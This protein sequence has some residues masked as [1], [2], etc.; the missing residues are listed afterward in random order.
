MIL[1][2]KFQNMNFKNFAISTLVG[3]IVYYIACGVFYGVVFPN[4]HPPTEN[5]SQLLVALGCLF[6]AILIGYVFNQ[7]AHFTDW[8]SGLKAGAILGVISGIGMACFAFCNRAMDTT[9]FLEEILITVIT[10]AIL[11]ATVAFVNGKLTK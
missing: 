5:N 9:L 7:W 1:N 4:I 11:G 2:Q 8:M 3:F 10:Y 6:N